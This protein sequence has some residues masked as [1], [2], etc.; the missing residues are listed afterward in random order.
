MFASLN[1]KTTKMATTKITTKPGW[2]TTEFWC[3]SVVALLG[4]LYASGMIAPEGAGTADK[5]AAFAA[6]ALASFGYS[7][8]R[9]LTKSAD[10]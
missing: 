2:K 4:I 5:I 6:A 3:Q 8:S 1:L 9:G 7:V 10:K